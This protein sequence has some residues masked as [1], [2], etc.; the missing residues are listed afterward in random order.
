MQEDKAQFKPIKIPE[1]SLDHKT[2]PKL[3]EEEGKAETQTAMELKDDAA[4]TLSKGFSLDVKEEEKK[5]EECSD[6]TARKEIHVDIGDVVLQGDG[7]VTAAAASPTSSIEILVRKMQEL[8]QKYGH[9]KVD[10]VGASMAADS[11]EGSANGSATDSEVLQLR[12]R[13]AAQEQLTQQLIDR[14]HGRE[15]EGEYMRKSVLSLQQDLIRLMNIIEM[16]MQIPM[17]MP[18]Q[19]HFAPMMVS[20]SGEMAFCNPSPRGVGYA[21]RAYA[22]SD[23][24]SVSPAGQNNSTRKRP[25]EADES[26]GH[27]VHVR[28]PESASALVS[29]AHDGTLVMKESMSPQCKRT[30]IS[31]TADSAST[32]NTKLGK[33]PWSVEEDGMLELAVQSTGANDWSAIARLLPGRC[34]KQCRERW[35][36][37]LSP[38]VNKEAWT[39]EEDDLIFKTRDRIGNHWAD[40]ARLLPGRTDNAVK[41]RYYST[42]RRRG[43]QQR[44][45]SQS[46]DSM[47]ETSELAPV[48]DNG[49]GAGKFRW[50]VDSEKNVVMW[51][52]ERRGWTRTDDDDWN[53]YWASKATI[54][55]MFN[56]E[57]GMRLVDGQYVNHFPNHYELTRKDLLV[58]NIKRYKKEMLAAAA[59]SSNSTTSTGSGGFSNSTASA[60]AQA[61]TGGSAGMSAGTSSPGGV[62]SGGT[63]PVP[64]PT[65]SL[66]FL[67]VTYT[68]P[69]DYS[70]FVEEFRRNPNVMW[71]MKPCSQAQGKGIFIINKLSQTKKWANQRWTN[72]PIK[73][74]YVVSR[75]IENPL[76]V[77]GK[78]FDLRMYVL[79]LSYRPMQALVHREGFARFCNVKYSA[80]PDD[81]DNPF[82]HLT[83]VA[84]QKNNEDYNSN[85]GGKWSVANLCLYVEA[86][87]GR[88]AGEKLLRDIH[89]VML[90]ALR[91]VQNVIINDPHCFE[92]YGY[93][94]I[95]D[96]NLKPW[97]VEVNASPS[98][99]TT[100]LEDRNMKSRLLRD[101]IE[102]AV[103]ADAG[104][105]QRRAVLPP[106]TLSPTTGFKWLLNE[107]TQIEADRLRTD[108][109]RKNAR[110]ATSAQWR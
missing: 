104:P 53:I 69:A 60:G 23:Q 3:Q 92:C 97:L 9:Q 84:V 100:T 35:V 55:S 89:A 24:A 1:E 108:A 73:E 58:K 32:P 93:D 21:T 91:A 20:P 88:G 29:P 68:L 82:M 80:A 47:S 48:D 16:Q 54:K 17:S 67:P 90:H 72:M 5:K 87:R 79:V 2:C 86:T 98:L 110:R 42:M 18:M 44:S 37:H 30:K 19:M 102:L 52:F 66:D 95:V 39:E 78:K 34:G 6:T 64:S 13:L 75:Y 27:Y 4:R 59:N 61:P 22:A 77:G 10:A 12:T 11:E 74:G 38:A 85:H 81:M 62:L 50:R 33:R 101:V 103:A 70:L 45:K 96:D 76:L 25:A 43:R 65:E 15:A 109:L 31:A 56:P 71:I 105:D 36:N 49:A 8:V 41:N 57:T 83:N 94:I 7:S 106:P 40:I 99:S 28:L 14:E 107:T 46:I 63:I 51:N 26:N